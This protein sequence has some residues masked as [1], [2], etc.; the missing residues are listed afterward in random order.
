MRYKIEVIAVLLNGNFLNAPPD[1]S[2]LRTIAFDTR[3]I[4]KGYNTLFFALAGVKSDGH[5]YLE[6]AYD[7]GVRNFVV[8]QKADPHNFPEAN[9]IQV[10]DGLAALQTLAAH[11]RSL[12]GFPLVAITGS[13][14]KTT[15]KEWLAQ[16]L[17]SKREITK[18]PLSY[19]SQ[20]GVPY[21]ILNL[22]ETAEL[23]IIEAGISQVGEMINLEK[24]IKPEIG[25]FTNIGDAHSSG[26]E[27]KREK[28]LEKQT[29]FKDSSMIICNQD[30]TLLYEVLKETFP[31]KLF[32][33]GRD[34]SAAIAIQDQTIKNETTTAVALEHGSLR[35]EL[36]IPFS[37]PA[38]VENAMQVISYLIMDGWTSSEIQKQIS[39]FSSL[40][41]R[42]EIRRGH[43]RNL[44]LNDSY[45]SDQASL[46]L[47][48]A[49]LQQQAEHRKK[50]VILSA[51]DHQKD[52]CAYQ[53]LI[54]TLKKDNAIDQLVTIGFELGDDF[55]SY[56][57]TADCMESHN[58]TAISETAILIKGASRYRLDILADR[59]STQVHQ[60]IL[61][62][63]LSSI[64]EN[65]NTY[66]KKLRPETRIMSVIKAQAY[67]S[68]S[69][70]LAKFLQQEKV[71][72]LGVALIDEAVEIRK[73]GCK[74]PILVF[75]V[76][77]RN[78][79]ELWNYDLEPEVYDFEI[80]EELIRLARTKTGTLKIHLKFDSGMNRLGFDVSALTSLMELLPADGLKVQSIFSHLAGSESIE[81]DDFTRGQANA[82]ER[83]HKDLS[84]HLGYTPLRHLLN[85]AGVTRFPELQYDM[86]R[87]G[88]GLY[89]YDETSSMASDLKIA[90]KLTAKI[91]QTKVLSSGETTGYGRAGI[92]KEPTEI[93]V[94]SI[95][96][97]DGLMRLAGNGMADFL[98]HGRP[99]ATIGNICMDVTMV[100]LPEIG[101]AKAGDTVL[102][103]GV[104]HPPELLA[105]ACNT[106]TYEIISR[107]SP[108]IKRTYVHE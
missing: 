4:S 20:I 46:E 100:K 26:F 9:L 22:N 92:V 66:R 36:I 34:E 108:R 13:N 56:A 65:L 10:E 76:Q 54:K 55:Q 41:N 31:N 98:I 103:Y 58:W 16:A 18:T 25:I 33:W 32:T 82:F 105:T 96:Y 87:I 48:F 102:I 104:E 3:K 38:L 68:G 86:V 99:C 63:N 60:T 7:K 59:L 107:I 6:D 49:Q 75:N 72:Y 95:G 50:M 84:G 51:L 97:A 106:I 71:D 40:P 43:N 11:H 74:L 69:I 94:I 29:L 91:L 23:G 88:L 67:G 5:L 79:E 1:P 42:L 12:L 28:V 2:V 39:N 78:L 45:S 64:A 21:T 44:I 85:S 62:T 101:Y 81:H 47:A 77:A 14:G 24:I 73:S 90:H 8:T 27:N 61:E 52:Q 35:Y 93:A 89:G 19:N 57:T 37:N 53:E 80:L 70:E 30:A 15:V 83:A 17:S